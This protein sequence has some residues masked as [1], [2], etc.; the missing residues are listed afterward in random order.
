MKKFFVFLI[1]LVI[2][3]VVLIQLLP[4]EIKVERSLVMNTQPRTVFNQVNVLKNWEA[5]SPWKKDDPSML[6]TYSGE[7]G[8]GSSYSWTSK[9]ED[10]GVGRCEIILSEINHKVGTQ[11]DFGDKGSGNGLWIFEKTEGG[12]NVTW[13]FETKADGIKMKLMGLF[14]D[15]ILGGMMEKG[16]VDIK[17]IVEVETET[18]DLGVE[19]VIMTDHIKLVSIREKVNQKGHETI[20]RELFNEIRD[21]LT[22]QEVEI[23]G[24]PVAIYHDFSAD[25]ITDI[26]CGIPVSVD[27]EETERIM[28]SEVDRGK[29]LTTMHYGDYR[30]L[31]ATYEM[32]EEYMIQNTLHHAGASWERYITNI[33]DESD[34][35]K[36]QTQVFVPIY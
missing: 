7:K 3:L 14:M 23:V 31:D 15:K 9:K 21:Y 22:E 25:G 19:E 33:D 28:M 26:E 27:V 6:L 36:H 8:K 12:T 20:H 4:S 35:T 18:V 1:L 29:M 13:S 5:W 2:A 30:N 17:S 24:D 16:L 10:V 11:L 34:V 32:I